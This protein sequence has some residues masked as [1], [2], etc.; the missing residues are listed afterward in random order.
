MKNS[1][2][3]VA[4]G[5]GVRMGSVIPKQFIEINGKPLIVHTIG[6]FIEFD[7]DIDLII[8]LNKDFLQYWENISNQFT[9]PRYKLAYGG[10][11]RFH[12][13]KNG[14][15]LGEKDSLVGIHDAVR[16]LISAENIKRIYS[17]ASV[18]GNAVPVIPV[19]DTLRQI[20]PSGSKIIDRSGYVIIQTPQ[21]FHYDMLI[22]AYDT[23]YNPLFTDDAGVVENSGTAIH[24]VDGNPYNIKITDPEDLIIAKALLK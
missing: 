24:L 5:K 14:L 21:V 19:K 2:I 7:P 3:I 16:P 4:G 11:E 17:E 12:S 13:V 22:R 15:Q 18:H 23:E 6:K 8:V 1:V 9:L 10:K 20:T